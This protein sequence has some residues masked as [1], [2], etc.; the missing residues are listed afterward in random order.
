MCAVLEEDLPRIARKLAQI[1]GDDFAAHP[2]P[3][4]IVEAAIGLDAQGVGHPV[5]GRPRGA[6]QGEQPVRGVQ[7]VQHDG[8]LA[9]EVGRDVQAVLAARVEVAGRGE[10]DGVVLLE[11][12]GE[13]RPV[14]DAGGLFNYARQTG[15]IAK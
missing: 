5:G 7:V 13:V 9:A 15:M 12:E 8:D 10:V 1:G 6:P 3:G 11:G 14:V 4:P 2:T